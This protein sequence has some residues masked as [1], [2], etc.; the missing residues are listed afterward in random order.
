MNPSG[1]LTQAEKALGEESGHSLP[2]WKEIVGALASLAT[3]LGMVEWRYP[4]YFLS[5]DNRDYFLPFFVHNLRGLQ[6]GQFPLYNFHQYSGLP[7]SGLSGLLFPPTYLATFFS[8]VLFGHVF[9]ALDLLVCAHL[10][11]G[12]L[13]WLVL[14]RQFGLSPMAA[15]WGALAAILNSFQIYV[16]TSWFFIAV[17]GACFPWALVF[18]RAILRRPS[19]GSLLGLIV[20]HVWLAYGGHPQYTLYAAGLEALLLGGLW[21]IGAVRPRREQRRIAVLS[22]LANWV[23][24]GL[25]AGPLLLPMWRQ[26][27]ASQRRRVPLGLAEFQRFTLDWRSWLAGLLDPFPFAVPTDIPEVTPFLGHVGYLTLLLIAAGAYWALQ[28]RMDPALRRLTFLMLGLTGLTLALALGWGSTVLHYVPVYNRFRWPFKYLLFANYFAV[29]AAT[30]ALEHL[31][32]RVPRQNFRRAVGGLCLFLCLGNALL[33]YVVFDPKPL[34]M[35]YEPIPL[36]E[37]LVKQLGD[38]KIF[39]V[40]YPWRYP[41]Q[42]PSLGFAYTTLWGLYHFAGYDAMVPFPNSALAFWL[43]HASSWEGQPE[44]L[45]WD[46]MRRWGVRWYL[47][48]NATERYTATMVEHGLTAIYSDPYRTIYRDPAAKPLVFWEDGRPDSLDY[49]INTNSITL[50]CRSGRPGRLCLSFFWQRG[51]DVSLDGRPA[52]LGAAAD[53]QMLL[54]IPEGQHSIVIA[55]HDPDLRYGTWIAALA[56]AALILHLLWMRRSSAGWA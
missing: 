9:A 37:P 34:R 1:P 55:Y 19:V 27:A 47:V 41:M 18:G 35:S 39:T 48:S 53:G 21:S 33:L 23:Y 26:M 3:V 43:E 20:T 7:I 11:L 49:R 28:D 17:L 38:G 14:F 16:S 45:P 6:E 2:G 56:L 8:Q 25:M 30:L 12:V 31:L 44:S 36:Q 52:P 42:A 51:F 54:D 22:Y 10:A 29:V 5:D 4:Y 13:G 15:V 50:R 24:V 32:R 40:G 46:R